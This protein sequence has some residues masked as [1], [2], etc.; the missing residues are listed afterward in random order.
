MT[1]KF[2]KAAQIKIIKNRIKATGS[3]YGI[4]DMNGMD[5]NKLYDIINSIQDGTAELM[6]HPAYVDSKGDVF[7]KS[8]QRENEIKLLTNDKIKQLIKKRGIQLE[9]FSRI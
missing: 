1:A 6:V 5:F 9:N 8:R 3:F 4:L 2:S 7:H